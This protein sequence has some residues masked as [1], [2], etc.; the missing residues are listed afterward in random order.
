MVATETETH[1]VSKQAVC[2]LLECFLVSYGLYILAKAWTITSRMH[3]GM[4]M[5]KN[6]FVPISTIIIKIPRHST[7]K[8]LCKIEVVYV[9]VQ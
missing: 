8:Y 9:T 4:E 7:E 6:G 3:V 2:S 1:T 5:L